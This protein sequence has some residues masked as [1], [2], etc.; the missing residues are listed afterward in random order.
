MK[1]LVTG[2]SG[3]IGSMFIKKAFEVSSDLEILNIDCLT[4]A[5]NNN[6]TKSFQGNNKYNFLKINIQ[7]INS[8]KSAIFEFKPN[9]II[10]FAAESH[11]DNSIISPE[12]FIKT[13][14]NGTYNLLKLSEEY[15]KKYLDI[16][17]T[18]FCFHHISTDE[19][20]GDLA[21]NAD[22]SIESDV[23]KPSSPYSAS[24][25]A[26]DHLV[27][28]WHR[29]YGLPYTITYCTNNYG[30]FQHK[31]KL[32]PLVISKI[33]NK[34][35]I[36]VYGDGLQTR[37]WIYVEDHV[38]ILL[39]LIKNNIFNTEFN[40][41]HNNEIT[42][43]DLVERIC[44]TINKIKPDKKKKSYKNLI[45]F[46]ED[47]LGHD[48]RYALDSSKIEKTLGKTEMHSLT[49]GLEKTISWAINS[50]ELYE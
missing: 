6:N 24:K 40:I 22:P 26:A 48:R 17:L 44:E 46:V 10:H 8:L 15:Y 39:R 36:P 31:E 2:G 42:N 45:T 34:E 11:V 23:Y 43:L 37:S 13:N 27:K 5:S 33:I 14:V 32:I 50:S 47:R 21:I 49:K 35:K 1:Y 20:F 38:K 18:N 19:V 9:R 29:T 4:Y 30:P 28:A 3:F 41:S 25:A 16:G 7:D 12:N